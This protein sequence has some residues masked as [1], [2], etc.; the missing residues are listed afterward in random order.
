M[1]KTSKTNALADGLIERTSYMLD[2]IASKPCTKKKMVINRGKI[3]K[4]QNKVKSVK[5]INKKES[6]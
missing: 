5:N 1:I 6:S 3:S 4:V 2:E